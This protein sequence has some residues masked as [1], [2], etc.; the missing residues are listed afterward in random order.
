MST[1]DDQFSHVPEM[2]EIRMQTA[3]LQ[4][5]SS[6]HLDTM[7][8]KTQSHKNPDE[9]HLNVEVGL[10]SNTFN[11]HMMY[12]PR[13]QGGLAWT[14]RTPIWTNDYY[15]ESRFYPYRIIQSE[16]IRSILAGYGP[17]AEV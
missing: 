12:L 8:T 11:E 17:I 1:I 4:L 2:S 6:F 13:G 14:H 3:L 9:F 10:R 7:Y 5:L 16:G 15:R